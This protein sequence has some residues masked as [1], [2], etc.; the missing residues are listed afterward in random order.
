MLGG[1]AGATFQDVIA[2]LAGYWADQGCLVTTPYHTEVGAGT[3]NPS[4]L[5]RSLGPDPWRV[6][7]VEPTHPPHRRAL[8]REPEPPAALL[9]V[10]GAS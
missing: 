7:Y 2:R 1:V 3:F 4:T 5:L 10:P 6:A 9:P 8:R